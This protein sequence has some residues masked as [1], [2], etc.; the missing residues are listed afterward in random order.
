M[1]KGSKEYAWHSIY[2]GYD[3]VMEK[4]AGWL[5][6]LKDV[7]QI[8]DLHTPCL[9][10]VASKR[11]SNPQFTM[12]PDGVHLNQEGHEV[13]AK[14]ILSQLGIGESEAV[15]QELLALV[16]KRQLVLHNAWLSEV[17]HLRPGVKPGLPIEKAIEIAEQLE[18]QIISSTK[19]EGSEKR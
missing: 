7:E 9:K 11:E 18:G 8:I 3:E 4:Y 19:S 14:A 1:P 2:E 12:S 17:G 5:M 13:L 10:Y 15:S 16:S 6:T